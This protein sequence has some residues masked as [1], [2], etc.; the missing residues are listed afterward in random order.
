MAVSTLGVV[1]I[2]LAIVVAIVFLLTQ[3][4]RPDLLGIQAD[5]GKTASSNYFASDA[6]EDEGDS[7]GNGQKGDKQSYSGA[8]TS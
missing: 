4:C 1:G 7:G 3:C 8:R 6:F 5:N 2:A